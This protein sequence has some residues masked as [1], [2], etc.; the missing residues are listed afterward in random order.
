M[1][2]E[3]VLE[4]A[5]IER[6]AVVDLVHEAAEQAVGALERIDLVGLVRLLLLLNLDTRLFA[7]Q[8]F[9]GR[10]LV[11]DLDLAVCDGGFLLELLLHP[12]DDW[13]EQVL[14]K[15]AHRQHQTQASVGEAR[16][17]FD[18]LSSVTGSIRAFVKFLQIE[19]ISNFEE[20]N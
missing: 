9:V 19:N 15:V 11:V 7:Q 1:H 13:R 14:V 16:Y 10:V 2:I 5:Q 12:F 6:E 4:V 17:R 8:T 18:E 3:G 20:E